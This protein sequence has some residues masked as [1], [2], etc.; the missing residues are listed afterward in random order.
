MYTGAIKLSRFLMLSCVIAQFFSITFI[1][2][3]IRLLSS[4][5]LKLSEYKQLWIHTFYFAQNH[6]CMYFLFLG[7][8]YPGVGFFSPSCC[9]P[10]LQFQQSLKTFLTA[11]YSCIQFDT[12]IASL[13]CEIFENHLQSALNLSLFLYSNFYREPPIFHLV[14]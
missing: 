4:L 13:S 14:L 9:R 1:F 8:F 5:S 11:G 12:M 6:T 10:L 3:L 7:C 2:K